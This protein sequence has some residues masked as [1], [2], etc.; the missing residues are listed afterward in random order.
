MKRA[1]RWPSAEYLAGSIES[2]QLRAQIFYRMGIAAL[3]LVEPYD[4]VCGLFERAQILSGE[5]ALYITAAAAFAGLGT[6]ALFYADDVTKTVWHAQQAVNA[7]LKAGDRF[8]LQ[9]SLLLQIHIEA[10]RGNAERIAVLEQQFAAATTTDSSRSFYIIPARAM[11][12][13]WEGRFEEAYR[14]LSTVADRSFYNFDRVFNRAIQ[15]LYAVASGKRERAI[16]L[17]RV[18]LEE[19][20]NDTF[21]YFYGRITSETARSI[22]AIT[23]AL[24]GRITNAHRILATRSELESPSV[25]ALYQCALAV[26]RLVKTPLLGGEVTEAIGQ[27]RAISH[28]GLSMVLSRALSAVMDRQHDE[29]GPLTRAE[30]EVLYALSQGQSPKEIARDSGRSVYTIQAH[31]QNVIRKLGCSGRSEA[32]SVARKKGLLKFN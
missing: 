9:N 20:Q 26:C 3:S 16:E 17:V 5:N 8:S 21:D 1:R 22:C 30:I 23:E 32:L 11:S 29:E 6:A 25:E 15:S 14:L 12:A 4:A 2:D 31:V 19:I 24:C 7:A 13:A 27:L 28:A 18:T 10:R